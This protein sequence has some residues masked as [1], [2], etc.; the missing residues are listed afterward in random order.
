[1]V[2]DVKGR[3]GF[4]DEGRTFFTPHTLMISGAWP[5]PAPSLPRK[6]IENSK[7]PASFDQKTEPKSHPMFNSDGPQ[8]MSI[9]YDEY[10]HI[11][12]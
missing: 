8:D 12:V 10:E 9:Q 3:V 1:M 5:P 2:F 11:H 6:V 4:V 7:E